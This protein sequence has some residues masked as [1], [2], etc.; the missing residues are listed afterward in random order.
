MCVG[1][2][3]HAGRRIAFELALEVGRGGNIDARR[4]GRRG[5]RRNRRVGAQWE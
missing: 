2:A 1:H 5:I 3:H 4:V